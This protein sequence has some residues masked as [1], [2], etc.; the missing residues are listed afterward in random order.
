MLS[1]F[2]VS[3]ISVDVIGEAEEEQERVQKIPQ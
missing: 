1:D 3:E 2:C